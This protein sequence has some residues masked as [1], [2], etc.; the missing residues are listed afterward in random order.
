M[1]EVF[2]SPHL[3]YCTRT[4]NETSNVDTEIKNINYY[5]NCNASPIFLFVVLKNLPGPLHSFEEECPSNIIFQRC[6]KLYYILCNGG[7]L[8]ALSRRR[9]IS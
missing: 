6:F 1:Y 4:I 2:Y 8:Y 3:L 7:V 5:E 9:L